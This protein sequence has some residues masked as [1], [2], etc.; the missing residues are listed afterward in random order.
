MVGVQLIVV[1]PAD[2]IA[3]MPFACADLNAEGQ[4]IVVEACRKADGWH[5]EHV[6]PGG[7]TVRPLAQAAVLRHGLINRRHLDC[8]I[9]ESVKVQAIQLR[10]VDGEH[11]TAGTEES[12]LCLRISLEGRLL[13]ISGSKHAGVLTPDDDTGEWLAD[14]MLILDAE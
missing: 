14:G 12:Y 13:N 1:G 3:I 6:Y 4:P 5:S 11:L 9:D 2:H 8:G 7:G 10:F